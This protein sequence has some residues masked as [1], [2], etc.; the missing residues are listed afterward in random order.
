MRSTTDSPPTSG[1][2]TTRTS[3]VRPAIASVMRPSWGTAPLGDVEVGHDL[4]ARDDAARHLRAGSPERAGEHAV[5]AVLHRELA[6]V[7]G[8]VDVAGAELDGLGDDR[9]DELDDRRV[10]GLVAHV[11]DGVRASSSSP[12]SMTSPRRPRRAIS[13]PS[14]SR[15]ATTGRTSS[16]VIIAMSSMREHVGR[17]GRREQQR[18]LVGVG[19]RHAS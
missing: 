7:R 15:E 10:V 19:D 12:A 1:S 5:D 9:V 2:V 6:G 16:A 13:A 14:S 11:A 18:A 4:H 3:I 8:E 17:V